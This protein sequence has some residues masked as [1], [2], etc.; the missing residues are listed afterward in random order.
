MK[1][2]RTQFDAGEFSGAVATPSCCSSCCCCCCVTTF[3]TASVTGAAAAV[4]AGR[5]RK[6]SAAAKVCG[7]ALGII[8]P[9]LFTL[10]FWLAILFPV[11]YNGNVLELATYSVPCGLLVVFIAYLVFFILLKRQAP[12]EMG[13]RFTGW[14]I[15]AGFLE[16]LVAVW[17]ISLMRNLAIYLIYL[18]VVA[19][20]LSLV[21]SFRLLSA[22]GSKGRTFPE[23]IAGLPPRPGQSQDAQGDAS[24]G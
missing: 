9:W 20:L 15:V 17:L 8:A 12:I 5:H 6:L 3:A 13:M 4:A 2:I 11:L 10:P 19:P 23:F 16:F 22:R 24:G 18:V 21:L 1:A 14:F 7:V